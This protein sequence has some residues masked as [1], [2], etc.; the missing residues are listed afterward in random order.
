[1]LPQSNILP[2]FL[3]EIDTSFRKIRV[4]AT[5][6]WSFPFQEGEGVCKRVYPIHTVK[7]ICNRNNCMKMGAQRYDLN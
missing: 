7:K 4:A 5:S 1:M 2:F 6:V 3:L